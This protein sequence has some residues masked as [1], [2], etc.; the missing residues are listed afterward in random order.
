MFQ[1]SFYSDVVDVRQILDT[2]QKNLINH[3]CT[4]TWPWV[5]FEKERRVYQR[6]VITAH[7]DKM[8]FRQTYCERLISCH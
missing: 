7:S 6:I 2:W 4:Q 1:I 8:I 5:S 3:I